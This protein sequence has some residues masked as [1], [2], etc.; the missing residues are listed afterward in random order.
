LTSLKENK[1]R[2]QGVDM[3]ILRTN[4]GKEEQERKELDM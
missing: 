4:E 1:S 3:K 2:I